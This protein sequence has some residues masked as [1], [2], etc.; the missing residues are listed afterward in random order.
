MSPEGRLSQRKEV[1]LRA[2]IEEYTRTAEPVASKQL[3]DQLAG[4]YGPGYASATVRNELVALE[5]DGLIYQPHV[6]AGR[7][8]TDLGYRY[9]VERLMGES[10]LALEEQRL[11]RHQFYQVQH[12]LDEWVRLTASVMAQALQSAAIVTQPR[13]AQAS[14]RHFELLSLYETVALLVLVQHDGSVRQERLLLETPATQDELSRMASRL[15]AR[16]HDADAEAIERALRGGAVEANERVV[17]E[18]LARMLLQLDLLTSD[19]FYSDGII[20]LLRRD[21]FAHADP[22]RIRQVVE[23][24]ERHRFIPALAPQVMA[25][26]GIQVIIGGENSAEEL[27]DMSVVVARYGTQ[28]HLSGLVGIVGPTR[29]QYGRA[30]AMVRY[31]TEVLNNLLSELFGPEQ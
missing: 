24:L 3:S 30:I 20:Q 6:S 11:I 9:F 8:P 18:S 29:M 21:E 4:I 22:R 12:Q 23:A 1:I 31:M 14:L 17:L 25:T 7:V 27:K 26:D 2:L 10:R 28:E 16:L 5:E 19:A 15:N 13:A